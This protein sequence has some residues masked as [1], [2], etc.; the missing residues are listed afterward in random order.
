MESRHYLLPL[1]LG[2]LVIQGGC[3]SAPAT[4]PETIPDPLESTNRKIHGFNRGL[5]RAILRPVA[6]GYGKLP[7]PVVR[8]V[9]NFFDNLRQLRTLVNDVLQG[10]PQ[11]AGN[12]LRRV[13]LNTTVGL[14]GFLD[15]A[16]AAG[17]PKHTEGFAQTLAAWGVPSGSYFVI[18]FL[19]PATVRDASGRILDFFT[20]PFILYDADNFF[21]DNL[22]ALDYIDIRYRF[23]AA[24]RAIA[25]SLDPYVFLR[26]AYIQRMR[27]EIYDGN[28]PLRDFDEE[29]EGEEDWGDEEDWEDDD[30]WEVEEGSEPDE[31]KR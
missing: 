14:A 30:D 15:P 8:G 24:D 31:R 17:I 12:S 29:L 18:P 22:W 16:T 10:K 4:Y 13:V 26:E 1:L 28:P 6:R 20:H 27:Y 11:R 7:N 2:M 21:V 5:D 23:L 3:A 25:E 19:G 9:G